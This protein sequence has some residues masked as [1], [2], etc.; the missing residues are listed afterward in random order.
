M[1][2]EFCSPIAITHNNK[3]CYTK[4]SLIIIIKVWN[5]LLP[6]DKIIYNT[7]NNP[8]ELFDKLNEKFKKYL[9]KDNT[10]WSW[11][12]ILKEI[13]LKL[14]KSDVADI[15]K[16]VEKK[17]LRPSQPADW[18]SNP[19]EWLSNY[20]IHKCLIQ[21]DNTSEY[22]YKFI[23]VFSIDFGIPKNPINLKEI[24]I[25]NPNI[26]F[27]GFVTNLSRANEAGTHWTSSFFVLNPSL[28]S[29]GGYYY[30]STTGKIPKDLQP[31]FTDIKRQAEDLFKK[32]FNIK[33]N[34]NRHQYSNTECGVFSI[35]FQTRWISVLRQNG[36]ADFEE[37]VKFEGYKDNIMKKL[38]NKIFRPNIKT[39]KI[40]TKK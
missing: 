37:I 16:P 18:V 33:M 25:K 40:K 27:I 28:K 30:D 5:S 31:V 14:N 22:K 7:T 36:D 32:P 26:S 11:T 20:D 38:R 4:N 29:Y 3:I 9:H 24:I 21:Y 35:A 6:L 15:L 8:Q 23:G 10:Y 13:A 39:L 19:T 17:D 2:L 1:E 34:T 12:E